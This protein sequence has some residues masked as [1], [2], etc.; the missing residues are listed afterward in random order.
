V[1]DGLFCQRPELE[2]CWDAVVLLDVPFAVSVARMACRDGGSPD[3][4]HP[5]QRRYVD[6]QRL[7]LETCRPRERVDLVVLNG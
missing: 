1:V 3:P 2:A 5:D 6:A 7:Y 4:D